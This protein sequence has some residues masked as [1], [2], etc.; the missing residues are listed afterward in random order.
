MH[1]YFS[2]EKYCYKRI[3]MGFADSPDILQQKMNHLFNG[4]EFI[5]TYIDDL[6]TEVRINS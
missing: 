1:E 6:L 2:M 3:P 4:P 5:C